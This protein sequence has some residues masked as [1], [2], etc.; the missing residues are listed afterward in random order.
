MIP[1][2][3]R[4]G[5]QI[6]GIMELTNEVKK[7]LLE[8]LEKLDT[9]YKRHWSPNEYE[10]GIERGHDTLFENLKDTLGLQT[11]MDCGVFLEPDQCSLCTEHRELHEENKRRSRY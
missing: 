9:N 1:G 11:C 7:F 4:A 3:I 5:Y 10:S 2:Q 6:G 8:T